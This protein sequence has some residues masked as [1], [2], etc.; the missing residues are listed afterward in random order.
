NNR[1]GDA[2]GGIETDG[3]GTT[4]INPG[5]V[6]TGN[7]CVNQGGG[8]WLDA[9]L[10]NDTFQGSTLTVDGAT[11]SNNQALSA[12]GGLGGGIGHAGN[13]QVTIRNSPV[14]SNFAGMNGGGFGDENA[15]GALNVTNCSFLNNTTAGVGGGITSGGPASI[16][17]STIA[18][19]FAGA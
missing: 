6:I 19:N 9:I 10:V 5:T 15:Q 4:L 18:N 17:N 13:G 2:G 14:A 1:A 8:I 12:G 3:S 11:I 7:T 16:S